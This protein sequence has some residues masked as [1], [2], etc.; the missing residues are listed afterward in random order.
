MGLGD[1]ISNAAEDL[2]GKAKETAGKV[3]DNEQLQAEGQGDQLAAGAKKVG[4]D[5]KDTFK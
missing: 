3:T 5:V 2:K 1:K 4:E